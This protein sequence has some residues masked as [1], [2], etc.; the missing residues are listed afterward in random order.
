MTGMLKAAAC[1]VL[2]LACAALQAAEVSRE[3][4]NPSAAND[5]YEHYV[6]TSRDFQ[7]VKQDKLW[8]LKAFPSWTVMPWY[9]QW[10]IG[11]NDA[12]G[13]FQ[14]N[15]G[16]NGSFCDHGSSGRLDWIDQFHLRFYID[17]SAGKGDLHEGAGE[18]ISRYRDR[19]HGTGVRVR[20]VNAEMQARL[21]RIMQHNIG[22]VKSSPNRGA[23]ALDDEISWGHFIHPC[24]WQVTDD[25][26]AYP[27]WQMEIYGTPQPKWTTWISYND[28]LPK[29][30]HLGHR[31][32]RRQPT[33]G[34]MDVQ[35]FVLEQ[36]HRR[37]GRI[38]QPPRSCHALRFRR[39]PI[40]QRFRR[41]RLCEDHAQS[42]VHR[43]VQHRRFAIGHPRAESAQC[44]AGRHVVL[45]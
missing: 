37:L 24:M 41:L 5:P 17:H 38:C 26:A 39:R 21:E 16:M 10:T 45:L 35:R 7:P 23:Y 25:R 32:F 20:P 30:R 9:Y 4:S 29:L 18:F 8:A 33:D 2:F 11:F 12:S 19:I 3:S 6:N 42:A 44:P 31:P 1:G 40:A 27:K 13:K 36:L 34:P 28:I 43:S 22:E 14:V 15:N